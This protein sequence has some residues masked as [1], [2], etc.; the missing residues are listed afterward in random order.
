MVKGEENH[1]PEDTTILKS[2][3]DP[4]ECLDDN[5]PSDPLHFV[6]HAKDGTQGRAHP[7]F[8]SP[9]L[10]SSQALS[11]PNDVRVPRSLRESEQSKIQEL[12]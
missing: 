8:V 11:S 1:A 12:A 6:F 10:P 4:L 7:V 5:E 2:P 3:D 9:I